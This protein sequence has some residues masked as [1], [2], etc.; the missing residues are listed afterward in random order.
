[1]LGQKG[2]VEEAI[3]RYRK[4]LEIDPDYADAHNN[5][6]SAL[7]RAGRV[8]EAIPH[9]EDALR[10][11]PGDAKAHNNLATALAQKGRVA[12]AVTHYQKVLE[13]DPDHAKARV[14]LAWLLATSPEDG[15]RDGPK[16]VALAERA[17]QLAGGTNP[18]M[19]RTLAAARAETGR[20]EDA[21]QTAQRAL[22]LAAAQGN[23]ELARSLRGEIEL[24]KAGRPRAV[25]VGHSGHSSSCLVICLMLLSARQHRITFPRRPL[26]MGIVNLNDDSFCGDGTLDPDAALAQ[27]EQMLRDG[28]D[29][30][31]I[32][33][34]SAR[35]NRGP[36]S[37]DEEVA[38]LV[39]FIEA[40]A[41]HPQSNRTRQPDRTNRTPAFHQHLAPRSRRTRPPPRRRH[42]Q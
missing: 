35:T 42:P 33:A 2:Q 9:F 17:N 39:P 24:Y 8:D 27:A 16:A 6:G 12:E 7:F 26:V 29:I 14:S 11:N 15:V 5:L 41:R 3:A 4:A 38:R 32:G 36:I 37:V 25:T 30:I 18:A 1:M 13:I 19:L 10:I 23:E 22:D 21:L 34:E 31:D 28:A 40:L 20:F